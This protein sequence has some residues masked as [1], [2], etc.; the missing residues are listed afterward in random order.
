MTRFEQVL[1]SRRYPGLRIESEILPD[2]DHLTVL[3]RTITHGLLWA[4][5]GTGPY[6]GG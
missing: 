2:E 6:S 3:P 4:L 5:P 1:R